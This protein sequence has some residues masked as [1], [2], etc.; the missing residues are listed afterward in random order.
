M[1]FS[2]MV[3]HPKSKEFALLFLSEFNRRYP[4]YFGTGP[5]KRKRNK[6]F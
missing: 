5:D 4:Q 2:V 1:G 6:N 3:H